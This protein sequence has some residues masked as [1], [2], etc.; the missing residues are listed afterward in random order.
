MSFSRVRV[1]LL[2]AAVTVSIFAF[3][4]SAWAVS[5]E[6]TTTVGVTY[7]AGPGGSHYFPAGTTRA[8]IFSWVS[9]NVVPPSYTPVASSFQIRVNSKYFKLSATEISRMVPKKIVFN[10]AAMADAAFS[11]KDGAHFTPGNFIKHSM[12]AS[13]HTYISAKAKAIG[14]D[15]SR[16]ATPRRYAYSKA[17]KRMVIVA[18]A[19]GYK[20][21]T[22]QVSSQM[23]AALGAWADAGYAGPVS[24]RVVRNRVAAP[25]TKLGKAI[26]VDKSQRMLYLYNKGKKTKYAFRCTIGKSGYST[27]SG[28]YTIGAKRK[29]PTW[30]N[31]G[32]AWARNMPR[33][34]GPG[35]RN[36]LG[37]RAINM[38]QKGRDTGLRIHGTA[39]TWE[40]GRAA[41]HGCV[42]LTNK[43]VTKLFDM[44][45]S[46]TP[47]IVQP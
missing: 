3:A 5:D 31:P 38:N 47:V 45:A 16:A 17:K 9:A 30:G 14:K 10:Y 21:T 22:S 1:L 41:S 11:A 35:P 13:N 34:I 27:P 18:P 37:V 19:D 33:F 32:S 15:R 6:A 44:V 39:R 12:T 43:N 8:D 42:R 7:V 20:V 4:S 26:V 40:I 24:A 2:V 29:N 46:G 28:F 36:P 23:Y 25:A